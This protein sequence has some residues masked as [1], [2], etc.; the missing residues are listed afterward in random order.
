MSN[1]QDTKEKENLKKLDFRV[2]KNLELPCII[3]SQS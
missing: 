2:K 1:L 3:N